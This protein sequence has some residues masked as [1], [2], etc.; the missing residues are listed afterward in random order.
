M[1]SRIIF[2][3]TS[4]T[5]LPKI[6]AESRRLLKPCGIM[7]HLEAGQFANFDLWRQVVF[8]AKT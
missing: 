8:D 6:I 1:V 4:R 7:V 5:A 2:H 3:E